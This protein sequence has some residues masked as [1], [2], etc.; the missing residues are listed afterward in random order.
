M[1]GE[2]ACPQKYP[3]VSIL[4][5]GFLLEG[6]H[7]H[8]MDWSFHLHWLLRAIRTWWQ[9]LICC[10]EKQSFKMELSCSS[11]CICSCFLLAS[12]WLSRGQGFCL[13]FLSFPAALYVFRVTY[14]V[15]NRIRYL[16]LGNWTLSSTICS[17]EQHQRQHERPHL[18]NQGCKG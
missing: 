3:L 9:S 15:P 5:A 14:N 4:A 13:D 6:T 11:K 16:I 12:H 1:S 17:C 10:L 8:G 2:Q 7:R 18:G